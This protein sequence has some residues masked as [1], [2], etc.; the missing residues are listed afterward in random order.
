MGRC[1]KTITKNSSVLLVGS[2]ATVPWLCSV[3]Q[4]MMCL[5]PKGINEKKK[6]KK[7]KKK[8]KECGKPTVMMS[9]DNKNSYD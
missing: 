8:K 5:Y 1:L 7:R 3:C 6:K 9:C 4:H 2:Y